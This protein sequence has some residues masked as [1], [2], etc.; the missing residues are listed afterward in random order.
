MELPPRDVTI[1]AE[2]GWLQRQSMWSRLREI[3]RI[4]AKLHRTSVRVV[5]LISCSLRPCS[6]LF[7]AGRLSIT[8]PSDFGVGVAC[9]KGKRPPSCSKR[10]PSR[11]ALRSDQDVRLWALRLSVQSPFPSANCLPGACSKLSR[12]AMDHGRQCS[13]G[14]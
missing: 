13:L 2:A 12:A 14:L 8:W 1:T 6:Q 7:I 11:R 9:C 4:I 3:A 5:P 10:S